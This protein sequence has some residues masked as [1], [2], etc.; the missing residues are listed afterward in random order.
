MSRQHP[1]PQQ[2]Y[3]QQQQQQQLNYSNF[4]SLPPGTSVQQQQQQQPRFMQPIS[5]APNVATMWP[6]PTGGGGGGGNGTGPTQITIPH[7]APLIPMEMPFVQTP[8]GPVF[9]PPP[10]LGTVTDQQQTSGFSLENF[11]QALSDIKQYLPSS[12]TGIQQA[13]E[14]AAVTSNN[15]QPSLLWGRQQKPSVYEMELED[16]QHFAMSLLDSSGL[17]NGSAPAQ[18]EAYDPENADF[19]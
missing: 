11:T 8:N 12:N 16:G 17:L 19:T 15:Y 14:A 2:F 3:Y 5:F 6:F 1:P 13:P 9:T 7:G 4:Q 18:I 10:Q